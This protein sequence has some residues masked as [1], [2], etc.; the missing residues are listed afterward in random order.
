MI[1]LF[2]CDEQGLLRSPFKENVWPQAS[3]G[4]LKLPQTSLP[5][6]TLS[7]PK[8]QL[9]CSS[10]PWPTMQGTEAW[11]CQPNRDDFGGPWTLQSCPSLAKTSQFNFFSSPILLIF[12]LSVGS[13]PDSLL[14]QFP[15][16]VCFRRTQ[17]AASFLREWGRCVSQ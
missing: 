8:G 9:P 1:H 16:C 4:C 2:L 13:D 3:G 10:N 5:C 12:F 17:S 6:R 15:P 14:A 7:C 11:P